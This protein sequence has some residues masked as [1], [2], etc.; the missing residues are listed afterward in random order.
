VVRE[1]NLYHGTGDTN[2]THYGEDI[3]DNRLPAMWSAV[4][5][6]AG[7]PA[8]RAAVAEWNRTH[9]RVRRGLALTPVKFGISFTLTHY[10]QG[11]ALVHVY[12]DGT[13]QVNHGGTEMGQG[14][15]TKVLGVAMRE[16][17]L[18]AASIRMMKTSTD[19]V[20]N[21]SA[22]AASAGADLNGAA[23]R[24]A[25]E[26]LR[27]RMA[28]VAVNLLAA[29]PV[30]GRTRKQLLMAEDVRFEQGQVFATSM[31]EVRLPFAKVAQQCYVDRVSL[32]ATGYYATPGIH[33]DWK[34]V[35][36]RPFAYFA[37]GAAVCEVEVDG[38]SGMSRV[39][40]VDIV[41]DVGDSLNPG[42]D[43][44][45]IEGGFVQGLGWLTSEELKWDAKG[46]LLT[47]S[48]STYQ[49]PAISDAPME[50]NVTLL[51]NAANSKAVHGSKAVGEPP[52][53]LAI[54]VREA[55]RDAVASFGPPGGEVR[56][57]SPATGEAVFAAIAERLR[58]AG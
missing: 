19:K 44:G 23:V 45:Q 38:Y 6:S 5:E 57:A 54:S 2:R 20:P 50:F 43:R 32:S 25:C 10:N 51:P 18:P 9:P 12:Q 1:R 34:T 3:G 24:A 39:V 11:G 47:H 26:T 16:L 22:T 52:L 42:L 58:R 35:S 33:W 15:H 27:V 40:R 7:W 48:A 41:H 13:V 14:L 21:T 56:L 46:R 36:G 31:P 8:R 37:C 53:M 49:I 29:I 55:I 4:L 17:G 30:P 28:A